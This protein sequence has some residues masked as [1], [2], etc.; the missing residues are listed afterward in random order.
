MLPGQVEQPAHGTRHDGTAAQVQWIEHADLYMRMRRQ[1]RDNS[2][3]VIAGGVIEQDPDADATVGGDEQLAHQYP[4]TDAVVDDVVLQ[5]DAA[6][7]IANQLGACGESLGTIGIQAKARLAPM[8]GCLGL[9][10]T[11]ERRIVR[12]Q[13][14]TGFVRDSGCCTT[15]KQQGK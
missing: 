15:N 4:S 3:Q 6:L 10:R 12:R 5:V 7:S 13:G 11:T 9:D 1:C 14:L 8:G 2:L